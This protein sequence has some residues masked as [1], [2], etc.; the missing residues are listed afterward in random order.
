MKIL[1]FKINPETM[2]S[3]EVPVP[4]GSKP[5][6]VIIPKSVANL[7]GVVAIELEPMILVGVPD[8]ADQDSEHVTLNIQIV[9]AGC[10]GEGYEYL[11]SI[12]WNGN[13]VHLFWGMA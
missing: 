6:S 13:L 10:S 7:V 8:E 12:F 11:D 5:L 2:E 3:A 1:G 9:R 4:V